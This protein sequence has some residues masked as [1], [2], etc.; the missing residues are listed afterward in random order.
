[1]EACTAIWRDLRSLGI[2]HFAGCSMFGPGPLL[3]LYEG[4]PSCPELLLR[5]LI[6]SVPGS[7]LAATITLQKA[8]CGLLQGSQAAASLSPGER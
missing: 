7:C 4:Q 8:L 3:G 5:P 2:C 6:Q 1:M